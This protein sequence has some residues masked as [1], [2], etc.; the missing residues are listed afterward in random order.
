MRFIVD[1]AIWELF[2]GMRLV[3][4][5]ADGIENRTARP[6]LEA[7]LEAAVGELSAGWRYPNPQSHPH[8]AAWRAA[9][10]A[11]GFSGKRY[12]SSIEALTRRALSGRG[13]GSINPLVDLYNT[14]SLS[15]VVPAGG[16]D[17]DDFAAHGGDL[18]LT[19]TRGGE[20]FQALGS[21]AEVP[22]EA[23]EISYLLGE[24]V[25]T[26]HFV[27]RQSELGKLTPRTTRA[28]LVSEVLGGIGRELEADVAAT[29]E[30]D[31]V[32]GLRRHFGCEARGVVLTSDA[33]PQDLEL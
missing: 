11:S 14:V 24:E 1:P 29:V 22:V 31:L 20:R 7:G 27:W 26:R 12:P 15:H 9:I 10:R 13:I 21:E 33:E 18:R 23:G 4:I 5:W 28:L 32:A 8:V 16:W 6:E 2:P 17:L 19:R 25:V 30:S 3:A